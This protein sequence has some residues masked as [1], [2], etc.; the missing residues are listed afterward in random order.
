MTAL[1]K[2]IFKEFGVQTSFKQ[3]LM[4]CV[5]ANVFL[6]IAA[7][8]FN[9]YVAFATNLQEED[10]LATLQAA[11]DAS[12]SDYF[13][14]E[15][16]VPSKSS[17]KIGEQITFFSFNDTYLPVHYYW[18]DRLWC[19]LDNDD[20]GYHLVGFHQDNLRVVNTP[21]YAPNDTPERS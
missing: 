11:K 2:R 9:Q 15:D 7:F 3:L 4:F 14:Y 12:A 10:R 5:V 19:D 13:F 16:I 6:A 17:Y 18:N 21:R 1:S 20:K 8:S